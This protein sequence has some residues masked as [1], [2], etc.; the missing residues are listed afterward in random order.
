MSVETMDAA[1]NPQLAQQLV[2]QA[3]ASAP[4]EKVEFPDPPPA[5]SPLCVLPGG[6]NHPEHGVLKDVEVR[7]LTGED[8]EK[9]SRIQPKDSWKLKQELLKAGV[10][11]IGGHPATDEML[12]FLCVG[13][14]EYLLLQVRIATYGKELEMDAVCPSCGV[15][16]SITTDL[17]AEIPIREVDQTGVIKFTL[18]D[19][20]TVES[21]LPSGA[22][23]TEAL[24]M[25]ARNRTGA[26]INS[27]ML[28][29]CIQRYGDN[30]AWRGEFS[31]RKLGLR[32]RKEITKKLADFQPG[33]RYEEVKADCASC[34]DE[35]SFVLGLGDLFRG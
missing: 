25:E 33:P 27:F 29:R 5:F 28:G 8:E 35:R 2:E 12:N 34:G 11:S 24:K 15:A 3:M 1:D 9:I 23:E 18:E 31:A 13:D 26:E 16:Q 10:V 14:R 19:G 20:T 7:E 22:E 17:S 32:H 30:D 4:E 6:L 21:L